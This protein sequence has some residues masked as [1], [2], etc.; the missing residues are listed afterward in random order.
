MHF[1]HSLTY[2][3]I[4]H[5]SHI[6]TMAHMAYKLIPLCL[7]LHL[8]HFTAHGV[9]LAE[10]DSSN[11]QLNVNEPSGPQSVIIFG[12]NAVTVGVPCSYICSADCSPSCNYTMG[13]DDQTGVGNEV[14][15][16]LSQWVKSKKLTCTA[17]N[18][19]TG[20][21]ATTRKT[22]RILEGPVNVII[23]GPQTLTLGVDQRFLCSATCIPS[24]T[25]TW[26]VDGDPVSGSGDEVV[27]KAPL[28]ATS[29]TI[30]CKATNSV[31]GLFVT[32]VRKLNVTKSD[33]STAERVEFLPTL[34][35]A[36]I[37]Q[38]SMRVTL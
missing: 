31:S 5:I 36:S 17:T 24:C 22:L 4:L 15:F 34:V 32:A 11:P 23:S 19:V 16:T 20:K 35:F 37:I 30:I 2:L 9:D 26:V 13:V 3:K 28:D 8:L 6:L 12:P 25:Y 10:K 1:V 7:L 18:T 14:Q 29:G 33:R 21:S 27:I 38:F